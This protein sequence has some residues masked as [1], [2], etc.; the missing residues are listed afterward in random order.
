MTNALALDTKD[1]ELKGE[2]SAEQYVTFHVAKEVFGFPM[3]SVMEII[4]LP[5]SV[6]VPLTP[7]AL[8]GLANLRGS[9]LPILDLRRVLK[10]EEVEY[11]DATRVVVSDAGSPVGLVV[12][13]VSRVMNVE[14]DRIDNSGQAQSSLNTDILDGVIKGKDGE[15]LTQLLNVKSLI[16]QEFSSVLNT[17]AKDGHDFSL[18]NQESKLS[19]EED[20]ADQL[21]SFTVED[22]EY[23]FHLMDVEEIVRIPET[24]SRVPRADNHVLGL[25]DLRDRLLPLV[26]LRRLY[27]MT[28][29]PIEDDNRIVI[30]NLQRSDGR[31]DSVG[32][33]VDDVREVLRV[34]RELQDPMPALLSGG[35]ESSGID[36]IYR[37]E[38]GK[39][40]VSVLRAEALFNHPVI[41]AAMEARDTEEEKNVIDDEDLKT[42]ENKSDDDT[43][44]LVVFH[45][46]EQ[47][48]GVGIDDVREIT[49]VPEKLDRVPKTAEFIEGMVNLR[50]TVLPV[51]DL[52]TRFNMQRMERNE[53]Q[54]IIVLNLNNKHTGFIVDF[55]SE[56]LRL[57]LNQIETAPNLS[58][59]QARIMGRVVNLKEDNRMIQV[60]SVHELLEDREMNALSDGE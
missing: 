54:R 14:P 23:A 56:V 21:V 25:I 6:E 59:N 37:L 27:A 45:L 5:A 16:S 29:A 8:V 31:K 47:E 41:Q 46:G 49:R 38:K 51:L 55:V 4:R 10:L 36:S 7:S 39:R 20:D 22:Q 18:T 57:P 50:G 15:P 60:L 30:V 58:E 17:G 35:D 33:V 11:N 48:Y 1:L 2:D 24:V 44:Q 32:L 34:A 3:A 13:R 12:D 42:V 28:E 53:R 19:E 9:V 52:R 40:L 43:A 26:S